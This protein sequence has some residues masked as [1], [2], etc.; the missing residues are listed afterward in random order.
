MKS[1]FEKLIILFTAITIIVL[2]LDIKNIQQQKTEIIDP[3][4]VCSIPSSNGEEISDSTYSKLEKSIHLYSRQTEN[5]IQKN[6]GQYSI[7]VAD[8][9]DSMNFHL[10]EL[11]ISESNFSLM[12]ENIYD[13][14]GNISRKMNP[15][16]SLLYQ[17]NL[18]LE[19]GERANFVVVGK[20]GDRIDV[21]SIL[22]TAQI[23]REYVITSGGTLIN[24]EENLPSFPINL[25][26]PIEGFAI[27][28]VDSGY[29]LI[30]VSVNQMKT[31]TI[32]TLFSPRTIYY[33]IDTLYTESLPKQKDIKYNIKFSNIVLKPTQFD[34]SIFLKV[35]SKKEVIKKRIKIPEGTTE[36]RTTVSY[37]FGRLPYSFIIENISLECLD[38][39]P[40]ITYLY[41]SE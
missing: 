41:K 33:Y 22:G 12:T 13:L 27:H 39:H 30:A 20:P 25:N 15:K 26:Y 18:K 1:L 28:Q 11:R 5:E 29:S 34:I 16:P 31:D 8:R 4:P 24:A 2:L 36:Y 21:K 7:Q 17:P 9:I 10:G 35:N 6:I 32:T 40:G 38:K 14:L 23:S 19:V 37:P 3:S